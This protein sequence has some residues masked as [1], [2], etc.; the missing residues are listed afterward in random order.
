MWGRPDN[1]ALV[2]ASKETAT[3]PF[4]AAP[5]EDI[6]HLLIQVALLLLAARALGEVARRFNQPAVVGELLAGILLGPSLASSVIPAFGQWMLPQSALQ[7]YLLEVIGLLG[8]IFLLLMTGLETDLQLIRRHARTAMGVSFGGVL[9]T[10][11]SGFVLGQL[12]P[13][14][15]LGTQ[16]SR[17]VFAL[18]VATSMSISAIP[19]IAK[20][21][22]DLKL[23]RR[24]IGQTILAAGMSDDTAGWI[25]LSIVAGLASGEA[26]TAGSVLTTVGSVLAFMIVSFT[27]GRVV[28][29]QLLNFVQ[30]R[31]ASPYRLLTLVVVLTFAWAAVTQAL[32]LEA[33]LGAFVMGVLFGQM[34]RLPDEVH[35]RIESMSVGVFSPVFFGVAGLKVNLQ[36]LFEPRLLLIALAVIAVASVGKV[37]GT[38]LGARLIG[39]RDHWTAL[40]YGAGLNARGAMEII[41]ATIGLQLG[42]LGQDMYSI[43]VV[44]AMATSLMAPTALRFVLK[45]VKP[46]EQEALRLRNEELS[47]DSLIANVHRVLFPVR[48]P[49]PGKKRPEPRAIESY[50]LDRLGE[51]LAVTLLNV[52]RP[53]EKADG[54]AYLADLTDGFANGNVTRRVIE[55]NSAVDAILDE[56]QKDYD[57]IV[58]GASEAS[59]TDEVV[60]NRI[61][62]QVVRMAPC[63]TLVVKGASTPE[64]WPPKRILVPSEGTAASRHAAELAFAL[65]K[66]GASRVSLLN[67]VV[68]QQAP[69]RMNDGGAAQQRQLAA[70]YQIV[71][72]LR[73]LG[74]ARGVNPDTEVR[75]APDTVSAIL[76]VA[77]NLGHDLIILGTDLR[78][79][80]ERLYLGPRVEQILAAS[81]VP[82]IVINAG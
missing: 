75:V 32:N 62:D 78:P 42:I 47:E 76:E 35:S 28:V 39:K 58:L 56:A 17:L 67:V 63:P 10:F 34:R 13:E 18:F 61:V 26:V 20:V 59:G 53:G 23:M 9:V 45:R 46:D 80:S 36:S 71:N 12:L 57:L 49:R 25:L 65:A 16:H 81:K 52:A 55:S 43:I 60:F 70:A 29:R 44:M 79:G 50:V 54:Q 40:A 30:D 24:D 48:G 5:H 15:L 19:V 27:L 68:E 31:I 22:I 72:N 33:V 66:G 82:V 38:Y 14:S 4:T 74:E 8:A 64:A 37:A 2:R 77:A 21:L 41:M 69:Y 7:G 6:L 51:D 11:S 3:A 1:Q 73:E